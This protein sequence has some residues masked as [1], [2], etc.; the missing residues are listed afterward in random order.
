MTIH[1]QVSITPPRFTGFV[2]ARLRR[3]TRFDAALERAFRRRNAK[4][5]HMDTDRIEGKTKE[6]E[7]ETQQKWGEAKDE[8]RD[9]W[10]DVKDKTEDVADSAED[11]LD[12]DDEV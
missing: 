3:K 5:D 1:S 8:A 12:R 2:P 4:G 10:E 6:V 11:K 7:G 9:K